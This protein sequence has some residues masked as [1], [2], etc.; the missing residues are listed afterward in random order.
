VDAFAHEIIHAADFTR[1]PI[2]Y[3]LNVWRESPVGPHT[4]G[5]LDT[6]H[7]FRMLAQG[8]SEINAH[9]VQAATWRVGFTPAIEWGRAHSRRYNANSSTV[10]V[11][12]SVE[13]YFSFMAR[14]SDHLST[15]TAPSVATM[16]DTHGTTFSEVLHLPNINEVVTNFLRGHEQLRHIRS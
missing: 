12:D 3:L 11:L 9:T 10:R 14:H 4:A 6:E 2:S 15:I 7:P 8:L 16:E 5:R 1:E 13:D